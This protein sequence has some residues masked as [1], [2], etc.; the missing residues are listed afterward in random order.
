M[1]SSKIETQNN[2]TQITNKMTPGRSMISIN[3]NKELIY[4][5]RDNSTS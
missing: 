1:L 5:Q 3:R 2:H 4:D